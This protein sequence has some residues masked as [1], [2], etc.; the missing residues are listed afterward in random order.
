MPPKTRSTKLTSPEGK[1]ATPDN[2]AALGDDVI[3]EM[4]AGAKDSDDPNR[5]LLL[6]IIANQK[7]S[8]EKHEKRVSNIDSSIQA[9]KLTLEKHIEE[10]SKDL[11]T[12]TGNITK[13]T[14]D[15]QSLQKSVTTLQADL[16]SMQ[17]KYEATQRLLDVMTTS[18][19]KY[20]ATIGKMDL[21]FRRDEEEVMKCQMII[22]G[23]KGHGNK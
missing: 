4:T 5:L 11:S 18:L 3:P 12:M 8:D 23:V 17:D 1:Q 7:I 22:D 14:T 10:N 19:N 9:S 13:N 21:K 2:M 15:L 20:A 6:N 16:A